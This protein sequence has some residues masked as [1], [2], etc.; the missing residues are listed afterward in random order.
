MLI[1]IRRIGDDPFPVGD[2]FDLIG[3]V[4]CAGSGIEFGID[5]LYLTQLV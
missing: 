5:Y 2:G 3:I 4:L 1:P